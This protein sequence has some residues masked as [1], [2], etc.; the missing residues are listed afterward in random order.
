MRVDIPSLSLQSDFKQ[1][2]TND[3]LGRQFVEVKIA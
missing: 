1:N 2:S 3:V